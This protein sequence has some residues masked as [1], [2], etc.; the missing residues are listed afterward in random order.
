MKIYVVVNKSD[1]K[2]RS[3]WSTGTRIWTKEHNARL[4]LSKNNWRKDVL[5]LHEYDLSQ[6]E[7]KVIT[8]ENK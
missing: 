8:S 3:N 6:I 2:L 7:P 5:E 1:R 4:F